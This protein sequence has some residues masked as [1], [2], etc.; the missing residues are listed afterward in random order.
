MSD[1]EIRAIREGRFGGFP[2]AEVALLR[3]ADAVSDIRRMS[4]T[5]CTPNCGSTSPIPTDR[6]GCGGGAGKLP[7]ATTPCSM[8]AATDSIA[9]LCV[10]R[11]TVSLSWANAGRAS[12]HLSMMA[13]RRNAVSLQRSGNPH[14]IRNAS[15]G[16]ILAAR[17][18]G[19]NPASAAAA[20]R[21]AIAI[22][23]LTGSEA[24]TPKSWLAMNR[25]PSSATGTPIARPIAICRNAPRSTNCMTLPRSAPNAMRKPIS[26]VRRATL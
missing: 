23:M 15:I 4:A 22:P 16:S 6:A 13:I 17:L 19:M 7:R 24:R 9:W 2:P 8:W 26:L 1:D 5:S 10:S 14:S 25:P 20:D 11:S 3:M 18:A 12:Q 21:T